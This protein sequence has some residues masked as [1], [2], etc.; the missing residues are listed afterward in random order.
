MVMR[1][2]LGRTCTTERP[3][4]ISGRRWRDKGEDQNSK[5]G[6]PH[7]APAARISHCLHRE[8]GRTV[9]LPRTAV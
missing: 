6:L 2:V 9:K 8:C 1:S 4:G 5:G 3:A 7:V